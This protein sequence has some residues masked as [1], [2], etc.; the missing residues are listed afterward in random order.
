MYWPHE[1]SRLNPM[2]CPMISVMIFLLS[3]TSVILAPRLALG[4]ELGGEPLVWQS[5]GIEGF[6]TLPLGHEKTVNQYIFTQPITLPIFFKYAASDQFRFLWFVLPLGF[7]VPILTSETV[8]IELEYYNHIGSHKL[9]TLTPYLWI[10]WAWIFARDM[11]LEGRLIGETIL[12]FKERVVDTTLGGQVGPRFFFGD[13]LSAKGE[14]AAV[15]EK[16]AEVYAPALWAAASLRWEFTDGFLLQL[17]GERRLLG[18]RI[19][20]AGETVASAE[21]RFWWE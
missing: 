6:A 11:R 19:L 13:R 10:N 2:K 15:F 9:P 14:L 8:R 17:S 20:E 18:N 5:G 4:H 7:T 1:E 16:R 3:L 12:R 21:L